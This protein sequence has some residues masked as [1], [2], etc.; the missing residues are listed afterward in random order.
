MILPGVRCVPGHGGMEVLRHERGPGLLEYGC[1]D[2]STLLRVLG[3][4]QLL[5]EELIRGPPDL[6]ANA[7]R[8]AEW[9]DRGTS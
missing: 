3:Y 2:L 4:E 9:P 6:R 7:I 8:Q 5:E 1:G